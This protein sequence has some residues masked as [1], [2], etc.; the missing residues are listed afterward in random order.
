[1]LNFQGVSS[2][3]WETWCTFFFCEDRPVNSWPV[4]CWTKQSDNHFLNS[5]FGLSVPPLPVSSWGSFKAYNVV[6]FLQAM[7]IGDGAQ[8]ITR[9]NGGTTPMNRY[10]PS[11][12]FTARAPAPKRNAPRGYY[13]LQK[14]GTNPW[15]VGL[16]T[17]FLGTTGVHQSSCPQKQ[18]FFFAGL[19]NQWFNKHLI[20]PAISG[21]L[22]AQLDDKWHSLWQRMF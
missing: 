21:D 4:S 9:D 18:V 14:L 16:A 1:M 20:R 6:F 8:V 22:A 5:C 15:L 17:R 10:T 12:C 7:L 11:T 19:R 3:L 13:S 2:N